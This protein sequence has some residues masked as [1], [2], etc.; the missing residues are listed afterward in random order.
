MCIKFNDEISGGDGYA[1]GD[2]EDH[3][4]FSSFDMFNE[5]L[6]GYVSVSS[7]GFNQAFYFP[8]IMSGQYQKTL[9][10]FIFRFDSKY[11]L[12]EKTYFLNTIQKYLT[13]NYIKNI[14][15]EKIKEDPLSLLDEI[16]ID[17][18]SGE[19]QKFFIN[20]EENYFCL[21]PIIM[22]NLDK[23]NEHVLS[24]IYIYNKK[25]FYE[26]ILKYIKE[27]YSRL[28]FHLILYIFLACVLLYIIS[29]SF[30][31]LAKIIVIPIK[32]IHYMLEGINIGGEFRL[33][34]ISNLQKKQEDNLEKL[35]KINHRLM[36]KYTNQSKN[37]DLNELTS[38]DKEKSKKLDMSPANLKFS[39]KK[40]TPRSINS[41][42]KKENTSKDELKGLQN[43]IIGVKTPK[44]TDSKLKTKTILE[45]ER[46]SSSKN[47]INN[48]EGSEIKNFDLDE[49]N[50]DKGI[51]Y[52][53]KYD[54]DGIMLEKELNF[55][56]FD[57]ELLQYRP[58]ELNNLVQSLLNLKSALILTSKRKEGENII[59]YTNS[60]YTFDNFKNQTGSRMCQS[61]IG[62]MQSRLDKYDKA[63]YHL[64]LSLQNVD[65][66]KFLS[67]T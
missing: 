46:L 30:K 47:E 11:F 24:I 32:N 67:S 26:H 35:N 55:Y 59:G 64:C 16:F 54:Y 4:L 37:L 23:Q 43:S 1:C 62:N 66:K 41:S 53:K 57:E 8:Q 34:Y 60:G 7:V 12:D 14:N 58:V 15:N 56:D 25:T 51:N 13:S 28:I 33:K 61:N 2:S 3:T 19:K 5:K 20:N 52:E 27:S 45:E 18:A 50:I 17:A 9:G 42:R 65:L 22:E 21:F 49:Q 6:L 40:L 29:L 48:D 38:N 10:E 63:I 36:Q 44:Y 39:Q 31:L